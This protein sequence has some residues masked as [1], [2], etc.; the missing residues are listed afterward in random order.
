MQVAIR[1]LRAEF[2]SFNNLDPWEVIVDRRS[3]LGNPFIMRG[4][5]QR[6]EVC[7]QYDAYFRKKVESNDPAFLK[8]LCRIQEIA[9]QYNQIT[10]FCW[11]APKR[12]HAQTIANWLLATVSA[13]EPTQTMQ[14]VSANIVR[15]LRTGNVSGE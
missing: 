12:C 10:L 14:T 11:C 13:Q 4:E 3:P 1:N 7:N 2:R 9:V 8:E 5:S 15:K 6:D